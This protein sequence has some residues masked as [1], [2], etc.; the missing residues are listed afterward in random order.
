MAIAPAEGSDVETQV[1]QAVAAARAA[2]AGWAAVPVRERAAVAGRF[3][4]VVLDREVDILDAIQADTH[5]SRRSAFEEVVDVALGAAWLARHATRLLRTTRRSGAIPV[6]T[7]TTSTPC[8]RGVVGLVT[9]WNYPFTLPMNDALPALVAGNGVVLKPDSQTP[10]SADLG[11]ELL[12]EAGLPDGVMQLVHGPG[13]RV[14]PALVPQVDFVQFTGSTV[15]G[16]SVASLA[17]QHLVAYSG[18][19]GGKNPLLVLPGADIER[20]ARGAVR[21]CFANSG[22]LCVS[23]ERIY[24]HASLARAFETA[25]LDQV[26]SMRLGTGAD[27]EIDMGPLISP[28]HRAHVMSF[29][30]DAVAKGARVLAGGRARDDLAPSFLEPTVLTD[31]PEGARVLREET[32]GPLVT[33]TECADVEEM[34]ARANDTSYGLN[35]SVWGPAREADRVA[36]RIRSGSVNVNEGYAASWGSHGATIGGWGDSGVGGRHGREGLLKYTRDHVVARQ[37]LMGIG[38]GPGLPPQRYHAVLAR[39]VRA[40]VRFP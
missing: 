15:T 10:R 5:K 29:I 8:P 26:A 11:A 12:R 33:L 30:E 7:R 25:F 23:I 1:R 2:Q 3:A 24:V 21:A 13:S 9:P 17:G 38:P 37:R 39:G 28:A 18:E 40:L 35:A 36:V 22:Q 20:A 16:R 31:V 27:W 32:F 6:L 19:L 34:V 14:G 4:R